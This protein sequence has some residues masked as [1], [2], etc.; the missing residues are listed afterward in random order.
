MIALCG[1][2]LP[3]IDVPVVLIIVVVLLIFR[4]QPRFRISGGFQFGW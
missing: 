1:D 4:V 3:S 2:G